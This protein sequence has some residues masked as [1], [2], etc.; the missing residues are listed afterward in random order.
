MASSLLKGIDILFLFSKDS[1]TLTVR[2]IAQSAHLPLPTAYRFVNALQSNGLLQ[3][4]PH[5]GYYRLGL[6]LLELEGA[7]HRKLDVEVVARP[8]LKQLAEASGETVQLTLLSARQGI[9]ISIEESRSTLRVAPERGRILPLHAGASVQAILA[10]LPVEDQQ[11]VLESPLKRFTPATITEPGKLMRRLAM[12]R[13]QGYALSKGEAY[14]GA[15]GIAAPIFSS[16]RRVIAS[17]AVSG[18]AGR[19]A[20]RRQAITD[21]VV[22]AGTEISRTLGRR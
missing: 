14:P 18:P 22:A 20:E 10:F 16:E 13:K 1:P 21:Q 2:Q 19:M 7:I 12:I 15:M 8:F 17:I 11:A 5:P 4:D 3:K 6:R 9:C